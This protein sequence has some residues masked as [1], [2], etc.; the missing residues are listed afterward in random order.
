MTTDEA[1]SVIRDA[2]ST[3]EKC[4]EAAGVL[5]QSESTPLNYLVE[6]LKRRGLPAEIAAMRLYKITNRP[7]PKTPYEFIADHDDWAAYVKQHSESKS[8]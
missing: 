3:F 7:G 6:C 5:T 4:V 1:I 8:R 2:K